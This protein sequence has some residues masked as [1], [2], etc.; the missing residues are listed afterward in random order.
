MI[1]V[2]I[3][4]REG[5][6]DA[7]EGARRCNRYAR[8]AWRR[9]GRGPALDHGHGGRRVAWQD[10]GGGCQTV[11]PVQGRRAVRRGEYCTHRLSARSRRNHPNYDTSYTRPPCGLLL[12]RRKVLKIARLANATAT[13]RTPGGLGMSRG[14]G[15]CYGTRTL[16]E[17]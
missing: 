5:P 16:K 17:S 10:Q 4:T 11:F 8:G 13:T 3:A 2:V 1:G 6:G 15:E 7:K 14:D 12:K 9:E